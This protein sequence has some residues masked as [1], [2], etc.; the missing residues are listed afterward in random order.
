VRQ[1]WWQLLLLHQAGLLEVAQPVGQQVGGN[2]GQV[3]AQVGE[4]TAPEGELAQDEQG[5]AVADDVE[6]GG[7]SAVLVVA[8]LRHAVIVRWL[9]S[10]TKT[11]IL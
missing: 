1:R 6:R 8:L 2:A 11:F 9:R 10:D 4:A 7:D 5:P 3:G